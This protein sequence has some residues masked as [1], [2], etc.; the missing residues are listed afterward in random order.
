MALT[1]DSGPGFEP[2]TGDGTEA[3]DAVAALRRRCDD[4]A[5]QLAA[6]TRQV[7][8]L[9]ARELELRA[10]LERETQLQPEMERLTKRLDKTSN[11]QRVAAAIEEAP[12]CL[13]PFPYAI[14]DNLFPEKL[15]DSLLR[16]IPPLALI[17]NKPT[18]REHFAVPFELAPAYSARVWTHLATDLIPKVIVP[19]IVAKFRA[20]LDEWISQNWSDVDPRSVALHGSEGRIMVRRRGY[21]IRPHRDPKW[22]FITCILYLAKSGD[23]PTWGTQ[24]YAVDADEEAKNAAPYWISEKRCRLVEDVKFLP[25]RLLVFLNSVGAHGAF[26]PE[27]AQPPDLQRFI[28]QFRVGPTVE[29]ISTLKA[30]LPEER[31]PLWTGKSRV[32]Y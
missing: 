1:N 14:V 20:P 8:E 25:N 10:V 16:G 24:L 32:D 13:E 31:Q 3:T 9:A 30:L 21:R 22:S 2:T 27:D 17:A 28:Y 26:I 19:R 5:E 11:I 29:A 15:Y 12:L 18:G 6:L 7:A 4:I 23:D